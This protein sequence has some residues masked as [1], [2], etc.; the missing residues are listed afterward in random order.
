MRSVPAGLYKE[1][2]WLEISMPPGDTQ[3]VG[4]DVPREG[5]EARQEEGLPVC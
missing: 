1:G 3:A 4:T 5:M 2:N